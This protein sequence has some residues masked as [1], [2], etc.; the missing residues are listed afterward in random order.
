MDISNLPDKEI[1]ETVIRMFNKL[2]DTIEELKRALQQ[3][4]RKCNK[5]LIRVK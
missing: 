5:E 4:D 1:K 3:R 2:K